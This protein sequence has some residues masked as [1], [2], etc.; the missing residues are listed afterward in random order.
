MREIGRSL[1][2][3]N[4]VRTSHRPSSAIG[5]IALVAATL[6]GCSSSTAPSN[7]CAPVSGAGLLTHPSGVVDSVYP[8]AGRPFGVAINSAGDVLVGRQDANDVARGSLSDFRFSTSITAGNDPGTLAMA[9]NGAEAIVSN[10]NDDSIG[11]ID[12]HTNKQSATRWVGSNPFQ[13]KYRPDGGKLYVGTADSGVYVFDAS[14]TL[15]KRIQAG[16]LLN[17]MAFTSSGC[18]MVVTSNFGATATYVDA[19]ADEVVRTII[20][21]NEPQEVA[22][23]PDSTELWVAD[24]TLGVQV[25]D[26]ASGNF[27]ATVPGT[28]DAWGLAM[29]PDGAQL[30]ET[31]PEAGQ[32]LIISRSGR[33]VV[34]TLAAG[35][36]RRVTFDATGAHAVVA[37]EVL[38]A[39]LIK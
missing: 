14:L 17:G 4:L 31:R 8:L 23:S 36:P 21:G 11:R 16:K 35:K 38:G 24:Q 33:S 15:Q 19:R 7:S 28:A 26:F 27:L 10:Y 18:T 12:V 37:D 20:L 22:I 30:Y 5:A 2:P 3:R 39:I 13:V 29:S 1:I 25:Y 9:P 32:I 34:G 6:L